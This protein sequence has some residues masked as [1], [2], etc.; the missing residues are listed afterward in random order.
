MKTRLAGLLLATAL[1]AAGCSE[2]VAPAATNSPAPVITAQ[3]TPTPQPLPTPTPTLS[4]DANG[5]L[6]GSETYSRPLEMMGLQNATNVRAQ[7]DIQSEAV[8]RIGPGQRVL[9]FALEDGWYKVQVLPG[10]FQGYVRSDLL[11]PF[12]GTRRFAAKARVENV[13]TAEGEV[14]PSHLVDV[15]ALIPDMQV[16]M[17]FA[18]PDNFTGHTLYARDLCLLQASTA[19][20]LRQAQ[21]LFA[22][23]GYCI[24]LYDAYRPSGVS[25]VLATYIEDTRYIAPAGR[26]R[27][28]RAAAV[29]MT[30]IDAD[31]NELEM[32]S[33]MHT[34]NST[35]HRDSADMSDL[36]RENMNY[37]T[38]IM[39][40]CGFTTLAT[41]WWHFNDSQAADFPPLDVDMADV[42]IEEV[43]Q[44]DPQE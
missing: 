26:S 2:P 14:K 11:E 39:Q 44:N 15:R 16:Y 20:K 28:N 1:I 13:A 22:A 12:D 43:T 17:I 3:P 30:L 40:Q 27:H 23:D 18:T 5:V 32:P 21:A 4:R 10:C 34:F 24:K 19:E 36:A 41:E 7:P 6:I 38:G 35:A 25:G 31:G 33:P 37:M 29:D 8:T 42:I 9:A